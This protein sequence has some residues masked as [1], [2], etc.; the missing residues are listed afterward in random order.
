[1]STLRMPQEKV[2]Q[3]SGLETLPVYVKASELK[4]MVRRFCLDFSAVPLVPNRPHLQQRLPLHRQVEQVLLL[5]GGHCVNR[6]LAIATIN[7]PRHAWISLKPT[8]QSL[9]LLALASIKMAIDKKTYI[10]WYAIRIAKSGRGSILVGLQR[11]WNAPITTAHQGR[12]A[13]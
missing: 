1:M 12:H 9:S 7:N 4:Q 3:D 13:D 6:D 5:A 10:R 8:L 2:E 11:E